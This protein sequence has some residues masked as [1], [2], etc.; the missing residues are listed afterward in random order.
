MKPPL[1]T[2][3][4]VDDNPVSRLVLVD[5]LR[6]HGFHVDECDTGRTCREYL[7]HTR[8]DLIL[9]DV[10][11]PDANGMD[12]CREFKADPRLETIFIGL[13]SASEITPGNQA[14]G[15]NLGADAYIT[16]PVPDYELLA[17]VEALLRIQRAEQA[18][19]QANEELERKVTERTADLNAENLERRVAEDAQKR[20]TMRLA[21]L[22]GLDQ[23]ILQATSTR[24]VAE[25]SLDCLAEFLPA[26]LIQVWRLD[27]EADELEC[28]ANLGAPAPP[29]APRRI[30]D[31]TRPILEQLGESANLNLDHAANPFA[32]DENHQW[33]HLCLFPLRARDTLLGAILV[34]CDHPTP[35]DGELTEAGREIAGTLAIALNQSQLFDE[36]SA[37]RRRMR[38]L[39]RRMLEVQEEER[40]FLSR[41]LH[42]EIGQ[43][44]TG[45]K[46]L[47]ESGIRETRGDAAT[48][49]TKALGVVNELMLQVRQ[50]S[51]NLRPQMLDELGLT[52][53]LIWQFNRLREQAG[54]E[55]GFQ[56]NDTGERLP[57]PVE[58]ALFRITQEALTNVIRHGQTKQAQVRL[59]IESD[60]CR[61]QVQD[62]GPGFDAHRQLREFR[63][64]GLTGMTERAALLG[65]EL[66]IESSDGTG[67]C[68]TV[69]LP[70]T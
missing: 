19:R 52:K 43:N 68:L 29:T 63:T 30:A 46:A 28:L 3:L 53:A 21:A 32:P 34:A 15:L 5:T 13:I 65:G 36:V 14:E 58:I 27:A 10:M 1:E 60:R 33:A 6:D 54:L 41:E 2:I 18:L 25:A 55:V 42:D 66:L 26:T 57:E 62:A 40:R 69:D 47:L 20:L 70:L 67:T 50:L 35:D 56:H 64:S 7:D 11:L 22:R 23:A 37:G 24:Q 45:I 4:V 61:L 59:W 31:T 12:L 8:P 9:L 49:L 17:R 51:I 16:R 44:L 48:N 38:E 39:S